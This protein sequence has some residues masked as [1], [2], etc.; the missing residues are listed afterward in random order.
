MGSQ[1][2]AFM[3]SNRYCAYVEFRTLPGYS[4]CVH[5]VTLACLAQ[6]M[7]EKPSRV[8][9]RV[10]NCMH[11]F[12]SHSTDIDKR[13]GAYGGLIYAILCPTTRGQNTKITI[14]PDNFG[15]V[16]SPFLVLYLTC[17]VKVIMFFPR[18]CICIFCLGK[19]RC[20]SSP[21]PSSCSNR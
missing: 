6:G 10:S 9:L 2:S 1:P 12:F 21:L 11:H 20:V 18:C 4:A 3:H 19:H 8:P 16:V 15:A 17:I 7:G 5:S 13:N 14:V